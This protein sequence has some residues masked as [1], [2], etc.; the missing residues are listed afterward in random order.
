MAEL[1]TESYTL[2]PTYKNNIN[3]NKIFL[4]AA[5]GTTVEDFVTVGNQADVPLTIHLYAADMTST[6]DGRA[7][8]KNPGLPQETIGKWVVI[9]Q[10]E[11]TLQPDESAVV[12]F[13]ATIPP[14]T[15]LGDYKGAIVA[16][17]KSPDYYEI[18]PGVKASTRIALETN[19]TVTDTPQ[20][21]SRGL[22]GSVLD[23]SIIISWYFWLS[24]TFFIGSIIYFV[25]TGKR[26]K[27][28]KTPTP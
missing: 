22:D 19:I 7:V 8:S 13:K 2:R 23:G 11:I 14:E 16:T 24:L 6:Q 12:G 28:K 10:S 18:T 27:I 3:A 20:V 21:V 9:E 25:Y 26:G 5:P 1:N 4:E 15:V 17:K